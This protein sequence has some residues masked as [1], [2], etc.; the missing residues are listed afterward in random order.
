M[1]GAYSISQNQTF[2]YTARS[3]NVRVTFAS[4]RPRA[5]GRAPR[6]P[7]RTS[8][9]ASRRMPSAAQ[10]V[11]FVGWLKTCD[12]LTSATIGNRSVRPVY[13]RRF[14]RR[15]FGVSIK[16][17][18]QYPCSQR[19]SGLQTVMMTHLDRRLHFGHGRVQPAVLDVVQLCHHS[20]GWK[21]VRGGK[22]RTTA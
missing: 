19:G 21:K 9:A 5:S 16:D 3:I 7:S 1:I 2:M 18:K 20:Y 14:A 13:Q 15:S 8:A 6:R 10:P 4:L 17:A 22:G 12:D 11:E